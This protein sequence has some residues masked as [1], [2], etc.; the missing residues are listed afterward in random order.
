MRTKDQLL[1]LLESRRGVFVSGEEIA[2]KLAVSRTAIWKAVNSL[3]NAGYEI[4]AVQNKGYCLDAATDVLS[5]GGIRKYLRPMDEVLSIEVMSAVSSTNALLRDQ[6]NFGMPEGTILIA[7]AQERGRGRLG[8]SFFS[9]ANTG[10]YMS[11]LLRPNVLSARDATR[12]TTMA[13]V[14]ACQAVEEISGREAGI[15]WVNDIYMD[16]KKVCGILTEASLDLE[17]GSMDYVILGVGIN[18]YEPEAGFPE[19]IAH[20]AGAVFRESREDGK[21]KLAAAFLN[22]FF[23]I[24]RGE[25]LWDYGET[26]R[27]KSIVLGRKIGI[28]TAEGQK[29]AMAL[30]IDGECRLIVRYQDGSVAQLSSGEISV[31]I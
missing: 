4:H 31:R 10:V 13:A 21:N 15:K 6:A 9:P 19:E 2:E 28:L 24:Y 7:N 27:Q 16:G 3:R 14:A 26:Y 30:D 20:I 12:I 25:N 22:H 11:L 23:A 29:E 5:E 1:A 17:S 8:R 18:A